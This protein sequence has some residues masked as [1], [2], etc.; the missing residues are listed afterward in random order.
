MIDELSVFRIMTLHKFRRKKIAHALLERATAFAQ[1]LSPALDLWLEVSEKNESAIA[2]YTREGFEMVSRRKDYYP[3]GDAF[4]MKRLHQKRK[5]DYELLDFGE[6]YKLERFG[7]VILK[8]PDVAAIGQPQQAIS[9]WQF[10]AACERTGRDY[11]WTKMLEPWA[12]S[13]GPM[14]LELRSSQSKNIGVFP[15]QEANWTWLSETIWRHKRPLRVLNLFAYTGAASIVCAQNLA[16]V[17]HV[18]S[19]RSTVRWASEN[20]KRSDGE[21]LSI[22]WIVDDAKSFLEKEI[23]R[24]K[25]YDGIILDPPPMGHSGQGNRFEFR[26]DAL[27]LLQS[28]KKVLSKEPAFFLLNAYGLNLAPSELGKLAGPMIELPL[29]VGELSLRDA[30]RSLSCS[31]YA[32][33]R[34]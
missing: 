4:V 26:N 23:K 29:E 3:E 11:R 34:S 9:D 12:I 7:S 22:R 27:E 16:D 17:T 33:F 18:D 15:E 21:T 30:N 25:S 5:L 28:C 8:R 24:G 10:D 20:A 14:L 31:A 19:A 13:Y 1:T 6:G 2:F 32:R